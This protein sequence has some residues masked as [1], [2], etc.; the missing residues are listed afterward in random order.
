MP[1]RNGRYKMTIFRRNG[2]KPRRSGRTHAETLR[3]ST[4]GLH[5]VDRDMSE[6]S[7]APREVRGRI[8][9]ADRITL[10]SGR[11]L[12][13][14]TLFWVLQVGGWLAFGAFVWALNIADIGTIPSTVE[15]ISWV[16]C[17]FLITL[18]FRGIFL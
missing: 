9:T 12:S 2:R 11:T 14:S 6:G 5:W 16:G 7:R 3:R 1:D 13:K 10:A 17:G 15:Q 8:N 18:A 4:P